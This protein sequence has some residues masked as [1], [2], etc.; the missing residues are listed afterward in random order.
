MGRGALHWH[1]NGGLRAFPVASL[2]AAKEVSEKW[3]RVQALVND[4]CN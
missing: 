1:R 4:R 2:V 3:A